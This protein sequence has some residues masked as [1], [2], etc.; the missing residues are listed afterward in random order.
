VSD[1]LEDV[2]KHADVLEDRRALR[3]EVR[4]S[5]GVPAAAVLEVEEEIAEDSE[6]DAALLDVDV[7][8]L[9]ALLMVALEAERPPCALASCSSRSAPAGCWPEARAAYICGSNNLRIVHLSPR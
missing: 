3:K 5:E 8:P 2:D 4:V 7:A 1:D 6:A 9:Y